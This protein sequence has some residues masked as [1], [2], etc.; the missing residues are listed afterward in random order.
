MERFVLAERSHSHVPWEP[1]SAWSPHWLFN[2]SVLLSLCRSC[3]TKSTLTSSHLRGW[4]SNSSEL[5]S[6]WT[7]NW[8]TNASSPLSQWSES[9]Q[10]MCITLCLSKVANPALTAGKLS[11]ITVCNHL[12]SLTMALYAFSFKLFSEISVSC[13]SWVSLWPT[14]I[15]LSNL[16]VSGNYNFD[17]SFLLGSF[18]HNVHNFDS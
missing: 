3:L 8:E 13:L 10:F 5:L 16:K 4:K 17:H 1:P 11:V 2:I 14:G 18:G 7:D 12:L 6:V 9:L 15:T